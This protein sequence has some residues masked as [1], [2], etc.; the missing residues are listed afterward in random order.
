MRKSL[1]A[2]VA[3]GGLAI[4]GTGL[5]V[6]G[7]EV[8]GGGGS[9]SAAQSGESQ[10][11]SS[12]SQ[13]T[14]QVSSPQVKNAAQAADLVLREVGG[15]R[16]TGVGLEEEAG[17]AVWKVVFVNGSSTRGASVDALTRVVQETAADPA[18]AGGS[19]FDDD[20]CTDDDDDD[21]DDADD[22][23]DEDDDGGREGVEPNK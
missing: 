12:G 1:V 21:I 3:L 4:G 6:A 5:A 19:T 14:G 17:R 15:G 11:L 22:D 7:E 18:I 16:V 9:G 10:T 2:V 23:D 13:D 8:A 20:T